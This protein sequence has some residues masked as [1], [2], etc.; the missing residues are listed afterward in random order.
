M[1]VSL[2]LKLKSKSIVVDHSR[3]SGNK[4]WYLIKRPD[5]PLAPFRSL[6]QFQM[7]TSQ[8]KLQW[9]REKERRRNG[10]QRSGQHSESKIT[11]FSNHLAIVGTTVHLYLWICR[12]SHFFHFHGAQGK[13]VKSRLPGWVV[14]DCGLPR[15]ID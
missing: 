7:I 6:W 1:D 13:G 15:S 8:K 11:P 14:T 10:T 4:S 9:W 2:V 12:S 5:W 3:T